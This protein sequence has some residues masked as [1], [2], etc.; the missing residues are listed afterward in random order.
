MYSQPVHSSVLC[1]HCLLGLPWCRSPS[2]IP[3]RT[4][5]ANCPALP[6]V[7][8]P[9]YCSFSFA[10][11]PI[12]RELHDVKVIFYHNYIQGDHSPDIVEFPDNSMTFPCR[13][14]ALL[15]TP[16]H[17][18]CYSYH[19]GTSVIVSS[20]GRNATVHDPKPKWNA[21]TQQS[22]EWIQI[23]SKQ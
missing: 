3:S 7:I 13:F 1:I 18:K 15:L 19:A 12:K 22:Q 5:S 14:A 20:K 21:Q 17:V 11:L 23:C 16:A 6:R 2:M 10:T 8:W 4:V 9:K